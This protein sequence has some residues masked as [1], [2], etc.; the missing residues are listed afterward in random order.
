MPLTQSV[1]SIVIV[2]PSLS[3]F[4]LNH[5][6][7]VIL[8]PRREAPSTFLCLSFLCPVLF[9]SYKQETL[10]RKKVNLLRGFKN[11]NKR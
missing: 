11:K 2:Q 4:L 9:N 7:H 5:T 8:A 1:T 10:L 3:L 6:V